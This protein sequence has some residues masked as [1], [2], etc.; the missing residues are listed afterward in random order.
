[1]NSIFRAVFAAALFCILSAC[2][3]P[4]LPSTP[5][6]R[7]SRESDLETLV[8]L[9]TNDIHGALAPLKFK[10]K[11][12]QGIT[13]VEYT[14]GGAAMLASAVRVLREEY[15][16]RFLWLD[17]GDEFQGSILSNIEHGAPM[18]SWFNENGLTAAAVGNHEF[19]FGINSLKSRMAEA[20]YPYLAANLWDK[21]SGQRTDLPNTL[22]HTLVRAG[23]PK[24]PVRAT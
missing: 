23:L 7:P 12:K 20:K 19:D 18:V 4:H 8:I 5:Q 14:A 24:R 6:E 11:E 2:S 1:M 3:T 15:G 16:S 9:G 13:S 21:A 10:S 17:A 22:P